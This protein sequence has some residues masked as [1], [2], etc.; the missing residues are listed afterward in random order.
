LLCLS[1]TSKKTKLSTEQKI[2]QLAFLEIDST[3]YR[4][5]IES[6]RIASTDRMSPINLSLVNE[7]ALN[8]LILYE[9]SLLRNWVT[10]P[11]YQDTTRADSLV[12]NNLR[13]IR[14]GT[15]DK[16]PVESYRTPALSTE[17]TA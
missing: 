7:S 6:A 1:C 16:A 17:R 3:Y 2:N 14:C 10:L 13:F 9:K 12:Q 11:E 8:E 4:E 15:K 5:L